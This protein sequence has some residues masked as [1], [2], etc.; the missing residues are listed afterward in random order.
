VRHSLQDINAD[1][2]DLD[3]LPFQLVNHII[4]LA[5]GGLQ[6]GLVPGQVIGGDEAEQDVFAA[7]MNCMARGLVPACCDN[8]PRSSTVNHPK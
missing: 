5:A 2:Y 8:R 6:D 7:L 3:L 4:G 1:L